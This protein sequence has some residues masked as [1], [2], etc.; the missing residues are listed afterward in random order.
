MT[1]FKKGGVQ[2]VVIANWDSAV[3]VKALLICSSDWLNNCFP[4]CSIYSTY[5]RSIMDM[6]T[7]RKKVWSSFYHCAWPLLISLKLLTPLARRNVGGLLKF[8]NP[9]KF[10]F[11]L[12][13]LSILKP[14]SIPVKTSIKCSYNIS[15]VNLCVQ[16]IECKYFRCIV[17]QY[18]YKL[19]NSC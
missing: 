15:Y 16:K 10:V 11:I 2:F 17:I 12:Y 18:V 6:T 1:I 7:S 13:L 8:A 14:K 3:I 19:L 9:Q 4:D 5:Q